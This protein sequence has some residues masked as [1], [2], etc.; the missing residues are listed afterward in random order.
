M[1]AYAEEILIRLLPDDDALDYLAV[2]GLDLT[3]LPSP[4]LHEVVQYAMDYRRTGGKAPTVNALTSRFGDLLKDAEIDM[5]DEPEETIEWALDELKGSYVRLESQRFTKELST[6]VT[7]A[8]LDERVDV[9]GSYSAQLAAITQKLASR[10]NRIEISE[11]GPEMWAAYQARAT[12]D[13]S[14]SG[15]L[16]GMPEIDEYTNGI[17]DGEL[18][19]LAAP[20]KTGKSQILNYAAQVAYDTTEDPVCLF[21][22]ENSI[23]MTELRVACYALHISYAELERGTL[24]E[25]DTELLHNWIFEYLRDRASK[26]YILSPEVVLRTPES[27]VQQ[28]QGLGARRLII[29]QLSHMEL[30]NPRK[31]QSD[32]ARVAEKVRSLKQMISTGRNK[33]PCLLA[34]QVNREGM[35]A[36]DKDGRIEMWHMAD[37]SGVEREC[38]WLFALHASEAQKL[39]ERMSFDTIAARRAETRNFELKWR[40]DVGRISCIGENL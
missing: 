38:D 19:I 4:E 8:P 29:D 5:E 15:L 36:A 10:R 39:S 35:K 7:E 30:A 24:D 11:H 32:P 40:I 16:F 25:E 22:L 2:E 23:E 6:A 21:S 13:G 12:S 26:L 3:I 34:H 18:A 37:S 14:P 17:R 27:I 28:A 9:L 1:S 33:M 20:A 31:G